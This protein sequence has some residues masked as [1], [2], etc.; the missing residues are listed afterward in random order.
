MADSFL[1]AVARRRSQHALSDKC[2][3]P[4]HRIQQIVGQALRDVPS[5]FNIQSTRAVILLRKDHKRFWDMVDQVLHSSLPVEVYSTL[6]PKVA[7][8]RAAYGSVCPATC[9]H[10]MS[11]QRHG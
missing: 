3:V 9:L 4:D 1:E 5:T 2:S 6:G 8:H 7:G 10:W 11:K